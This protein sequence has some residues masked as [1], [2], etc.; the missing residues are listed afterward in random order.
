[1]YLINKKEILSNLLNLFLIEENENL[2][3]LFIEWDST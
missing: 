3:K 2:R 1:M